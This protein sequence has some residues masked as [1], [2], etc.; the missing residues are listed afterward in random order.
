LITTGTRYHKAP[1]DTIKHYKHMALLQVDDLKNAI[2]YDCVPV[3][4]EIIEGASAL[5]DYK[6]PERAFYVFGQ[7]DGTL[8]ER[9]LSWCRDIVYIPTSGCMNLAA[10]VNVVLYDR[11]AKQYL[12]EQREEG[13]SK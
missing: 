12:R 5:P 3:A 10:T 7:E 13:E 2:P 9:V 8:G 4:I 6:H 1:T 11:M